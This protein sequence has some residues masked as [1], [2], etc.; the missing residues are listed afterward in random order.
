MSSA[1]V[2]GFS[3]IIIY[4]NYF[5]YVLYCTKITHSIFFPNSSLRRH[6]LRICERLA[7]FPA[8]DYHLIKQ[9]AHLLPPLLELRIIFQWNCG[10]VQLY[11]KA[12]LHYIPLGFGQNG[13]TCPTAVLLPGALPWK[14][15]NL[16]AVGNMDGGGVLYGFGV[17][18]LNR[19]FARTGKILCSE[20]FLRKRAYENLSSTIT[21]EVRLKENSLV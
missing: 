1:R 8:E 7:P 16:I 13:G 6:L 21:A 3:N 4:L 9:G 2:T 12:E 17:A 10:V 14:I 5:V 11:G 15:I 18:E 19:I 20:V